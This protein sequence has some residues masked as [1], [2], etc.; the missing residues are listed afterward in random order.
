ML[1]PVRGAGNC[2]DVRRSLRNC[3]FRFTCK[4]NMEVFEAADKVPHG[5]TGQARAEA[6]VE[7]EPGSS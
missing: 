2:K 7:V 6:E 1:L 5:R 3:H 4:M